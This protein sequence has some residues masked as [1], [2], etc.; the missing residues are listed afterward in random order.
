L[1]GASIK[2]P[3][4]FSS[5][6]RADFNLC[7]SLDSLS[8]TAGQFALHILTCLFRDDFNV[9]HVSQKTHLNSGGDVLFCL[10]KQYFAVFWWCFKV[11]S[12]LN[13][14]WQ[15]LHSISFIFLYI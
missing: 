5:E 3:C 9:K 10:T 4:E 14:L 11:V 7:K 6:R 8:F 1:I 15:Y 12:D 2:Y 13:V